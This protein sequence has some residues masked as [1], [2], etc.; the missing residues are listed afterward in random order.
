M[1]PKVHALDLTEV[2]TVRRHLLEDPEVQEAVDALVGH[3]AS[4]NTLMKET[5]AWEC[6]QDRM[7]FLITRARDPKP[8]LKPEEE[9]PAIWPEGSCI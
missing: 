8:V 7:Q 2:L 1:A 4:A 6:F 5:W 3:L 9:E